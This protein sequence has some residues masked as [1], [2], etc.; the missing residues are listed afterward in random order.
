MRKTMYQS[1]DHL[2]V[3]LERAEESCPEEIVKSYFNTYSLPDS[4]LYLWQMLKWYG[5]EK[6]EGLLLET[7]DC[8]AFFEKLV[9]L[10]EALHVQMESK[11]VT[12]EPVKSF[13]SRQGFLCDDNNS[14]DD[15]PLAPVIRMIRQSMDVEK[16]YLLGTFPLVPEA[17]G[18]E[19]D[20]LVLVNGN[21]NHTNEELESLIHNRS[22]DLVPVC[23]NSFPMTK[24]N[25]MI[26]NGNYF[27]SMNCVPEKLLYDAGRVPLEKPRQVDQLTSSDSLLETHNGIMEKARSFVSGA[28]H[29]YESNEYALAAFMLHQ[30]MEHGL[31]AFLQPL[32]QFRLQTHSLQKLL[33]W[34]RRF[35]MDIFNVFPRDTE[36]EIDLF[37]LLQKAYVHARYKDVFTITGEEACLLQERV[38]LILEKITNE[39]KRLVVVQP[40]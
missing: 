14:S 18:I 29:Y 11:P 25:G 2:P 26:E 28:A 40:S 5:I 34:T 15:D 36:R 20:L 8:L 31:N 9:C 38:K 30:A 19:Y 27:F 6:E 4:R 37:R 1:H 17:L 12:N 21:N 22:H 3:W 16:I 10:I 7:C 24:V 23:A 39:F 33:R 13:E 32:I 35:S